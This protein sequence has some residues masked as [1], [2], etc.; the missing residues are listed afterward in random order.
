MPQYIERAKLG[1]QAHACGSEW[2]FPAA[3]LPSRLNYPA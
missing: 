1:A 3:Q 2:Q